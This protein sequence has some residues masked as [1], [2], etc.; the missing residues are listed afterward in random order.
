MRRETV[1]DTSEIGIIRAFYV[2]NGRPTT[3]RVE[4]PTLRKKTSHRRQKCSKNPSVSIF[5]VLVT[6]FCT[7]SFH[8]PNTFMSSCGIESLTLREQA[9]GPPGLM[10]KECKVS[11]DYKPS[12]RK[13]IHMRNH[14]EATQINDAQLEQDQRNKFNFADTYVAS[15]NECTAMLFDSE[16]VWTS[17]LDR[18]DIATHR[19]KVFMADA[20]PVYSAP[21]RSGSKAQKAKRNEIA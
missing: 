17:L 10:N 7:K 14:E 5:L 9:G 19:V 11:A 16:S 2:Y 6:I 12:E 3:C 18:I 15:K 20:K 13:I 4:N 21:C 1:G 8:S